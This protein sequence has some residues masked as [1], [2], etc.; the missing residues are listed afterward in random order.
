MPLSPLQPQPQLLLPPSAFF[1]N[2]HIGKI[3]R[4]GGN[5]IAAVFFVKLES[6]S[7][8]SALV[9]LKDWGADTRVGK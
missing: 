1:S 2:F 5:S 3:E 7:A 6:L 8:S 9:E 4:G